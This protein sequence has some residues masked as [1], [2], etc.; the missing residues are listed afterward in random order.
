MNVGHLVA[1][2]LLVAMQRQRCASEQL[3]EDIKAVMSS[4]ADVVSH[5]IDEGFVRL[6]VAKRKALE[7]AQQQL[8]GASISAGGPVAPGISAGKS[9]GLHQAANIL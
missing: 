2:T 8:S 5:A 3:E 7:R 1:S 9:L 4:G 6:A